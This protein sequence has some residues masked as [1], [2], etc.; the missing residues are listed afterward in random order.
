MLSEPMSERKH[1]GPSV[2]YNKVQNPSG[3]DLEMVGNLV[4]TRNNT[5]PRIALR[6]SRLGL[7]WGMT[8][9]AP[10]SKSGPRAHGWTS[11]IFQEKDVWLDVLPRAVRDAPAS[12]APLFLAQQAPHMENTL[13][14]HKWVGGHGLHAPPP[15]PSFI[16]SCLPYQ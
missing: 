15:K 12:T 1:R 7:G 4:A 14:V 2:A 13:D 5:G 16:G 3:L 10:D 8:L 9:A 11:P 6:Q